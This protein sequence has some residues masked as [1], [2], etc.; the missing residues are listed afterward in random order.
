MSSSVSD[1]K[2][3]R[4]CGK[5]RLEGHNSATCPGARGVT[6][7]P[8]L[9]TVSEAPAP[10]YVTMDDIKNLLNEFRES[11]RP[12]ETP[13]MSYAA[14]AAMPPPPPAP[15]TVETDAASVSSEEVTETPAQ[16]TMRVALTKMS[17]YATTAEWMMLKET[18]AAHPERFDCR[19]MGHTSDTD[20][21]PHYT[22]TYKHPYKVWTGKEQMD[23]YHIT[24]YHMNY[25]VLP[26][27]M[28][29]FKRV[30]AML[31]INGAPEY[32]TVALFKGLG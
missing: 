23:R 15:K 16:K 12:A 11:L 8:I 24:H 19:G 6:E 31:M 32:R 4:K 21:D 27:G 26:N 13:R 25:T 3:V 20:A 5:C 28:M 18:Y 29:S 30:M 17:V 7:A 22:I 14:A 1:S 10:A 9:N 2:K